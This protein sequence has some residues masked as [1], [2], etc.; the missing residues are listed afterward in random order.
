MIAGDRQAPP[1]GPAAPRIAIAV[2]TFH[3]PEAV[4]VAMLESLAVA[5]SV[6]ASRWPGVS[7]DL[8]LVDNTPGGTD[9][10]R[11]QALLDRFAPGG[12]GRGVEGRVAL[13]SR[14]LSGHGN[15]GF[16]AANNLALLDRDADIL[17]VANPDL[18]YE[19]EAFA[20]LLDT[21]A[22][23]PEAGLVTPAFVE[24][25]GAGQGATARHL[26]HLCKRYPSF[27]VLFGRG[28]LPAGLRRGLAREIA[29]YAM[30][31]KPADRDWWDPPIVTGAFMAFR[32][33]V[34]RAIGGF[35]PRFFLYFEDFDISLR[36]ARLTRLHFAAGVRMVHDGGDAGRKGWKHVRMFSASAFRF[37]AK[38]GF[39]L[40][41]VK[42][43][44]PRR[45]PA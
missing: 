5:A 39:R 19:P 42:D 13:S 6:C 38:H 29:S 14:L 18:V 32:A 26:S 25:A 27:A 40:W 31:D 12:E 22:R 33:P 9:R 7:F 28:F 37:W 45:V 21:F 30:A 34:F 24:A 35:D 8:T 44:P 20:A 15:V 10:A 43:A 3:T 41:A 4:V 23:E 17:I 2:T 11:L 36:A 16:G 1:A